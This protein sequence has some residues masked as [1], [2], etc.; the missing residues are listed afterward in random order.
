MLKE[1]LKVA[2]GSYLFGLE[3]LLDPVLQENLAGVQ[4]DG[5]HAVLVFLRRH[6]QDLAAVVLENTQISKSKT[7]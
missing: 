3:L 4:L 2:D 5:H 7:W 1:K 6:D